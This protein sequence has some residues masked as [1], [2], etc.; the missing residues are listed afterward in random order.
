MQ[1]LTQRG[2]TALKAGDRAAAR[3]FLSQAVKESPEDATAWLWLSGA[4]DNDEHRIIC[5]RQV[6][7]IE[8]Q[9]QAA[10]RGLEK[11]LMKTQP[12]SPEKTSDS[13]EP[14]APPLPEKS[15]LVNLES[16]AISAPVLETSS[17]PLQTTPPERKFEPFGRKNSAPGSG[18][19]PSQRIFRIRPS[20]VPALACFWLFF[21]GAIILFS[22]LQGLS[23]ISYFIAGGV[24]ILLEVI[25]LFVL[26]RNFRAQY[27]LTDQYLKVP[28]RGKK[29]IIPISDLLHI[30]ERR[31]FW[32]KIRG[33]ADILIDVVVGGELTHLRMRDISNFQKRLEQIKSMAI[34]ME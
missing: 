4:V 8:P 15:Q 7:R 32:Q 9:N 17:Q 19:M 2:I 20:L 18:E 22:L 33:T 16:A 1:E 5:L 6:L 31:T 10:V 14:I 25:V 29:T 26:L 12:A 3:K 30:E 24:A 21:I 28:F 11:L 27:E 34:N 23:Q 13:A